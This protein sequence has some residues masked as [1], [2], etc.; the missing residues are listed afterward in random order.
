ML[1]LRAPDKETTF[2]GTGI[3]THEKE[4]NG[5]ASLGEVSEAKGHATRQGCRIQL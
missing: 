1:R 3:N 2:G 4:V 5:R